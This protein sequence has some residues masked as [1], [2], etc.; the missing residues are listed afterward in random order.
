[1]AP[2]CES[3]F[4]LCPRP[5]RGPSAYDDMDLQLVWL[6]A[7]EEQGVNIDAKCLGDYW[8]HYITPYWAEYGNCKMNLPAGLEPPFSG[9][10]HNPYKDSCGAYIRS[11]IW[12]C[13]APGRPDI[14]VQYAYEDALVDH[15]EGEGLYAEIFCAAMESAAFVESDLRRLMDIGL[16]YL[17]E[18]CGRFPSGSSLSEAV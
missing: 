3:C 15:G 9:T 4:R 18:D 2:P 12:A 17:P 6:V 8:T 14:A 1:M 7:M 16:S 10:F 13:M 5:E 11:E